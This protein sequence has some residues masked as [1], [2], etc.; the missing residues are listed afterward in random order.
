MPGD[1][2]RAYAALQKALT[3]DRVT[4]APEDMVVYSYDGTW[5]VGRPQ[6]AVTVLSA[7]DVSAVVRIASDEEIP[8]VPRGAASGLAGGSVPLFGGIVVNMTRMNKIIE[9]DKVGM[10]VMTEPGVVT[11]TL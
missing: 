1:I 4:R 2:D 8:I 3:P 7:E 9:I 5:V 10:T 6:M 11:A